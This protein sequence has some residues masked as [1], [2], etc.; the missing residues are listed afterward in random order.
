MRPDFIG[1]DE[2]GAS[3]PDTGDRQGGDTESRIGIGDMM[4]ADLFIAGS[5]SGVVA[6][7]TR[8][9]PGPTIPSSLLSFTSRTGP[10]PMRSPTACPSRITLPVP[11]C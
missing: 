9:S 11:S 6:V 10:L 3:Q 2:F 4:A 8:I 7:A 5:Q 1:N